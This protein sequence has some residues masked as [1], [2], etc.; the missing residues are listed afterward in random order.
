MARSAGTPVVCYEESDQSPLSGESRMLLRAKWATGMD[1]APYHIEFG[2][3]LSTAWAK[4]LFSGDYE[5]VLDIIKGKTEIQIKQLLGMRESLMNYCAVFHVVQGA[6]GL[7]S[8]TEWKDIQICQRNLN[9]KNEHVKILLKLLSLGVDVNVRDVAGFT[10]LHHCCQLFGN[11]VTL[12][13]AEILI[14][15]GAE[16]DAKNRFGETPLWESTINNKLD[17]ISLLL[18][19]GANHSVKD[20]DGCSPQDKAYGNPQIMRIF[21]EAEKIQAKKER[22]AEKDNSG[23]RLSACSVCQTGRDTKKCT[24]CFSVWF[25][26]RECQLSAWP[27]HKKKCKVQFYICRNS[28]VILKAYFFRKRELSTQ[29]VTLGLRFQWVKV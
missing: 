26:G 9:V 16:V 13:M 18:K 2:K 29:C 19:Y 4:A 5:G 10:P 20:N 22:K 27:D 12:Q 6:R 28:L 21:G 8:K 7:H 23:A 25:C 3:F 11:D 15:A 1:Y 14:K 24:G 17:F